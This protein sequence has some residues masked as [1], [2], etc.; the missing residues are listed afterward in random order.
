MEKLFCL[1]CKKE[2]DVNT[3]IWR[4][5]CGSILDI[6]VE[7]K[8]VIRRIKQRE[9]NLWRYL[10][11]LP[12]YSRSKVLSFGEGFTP[13]IDIPSGRYGEYRIL[14]KLEFLSPTGSFK[15]RGAT[16]LLSKANELGIKKVLCDSSGNAAAAV[17]AYASLGGID[18]DIYVPEYTEAG[19]LVQISMYGA[20]VIKVPGSRQDTSDAAFKAAQ[21]IY[22]ASHFWNPFFFQGTKTFSFEIWEQLNYHAPDN[23]IIP[24]GHGTLLLGAFKGFEELRKT[25]MIEKL[26]RI[27]AVQSESCAPIYEIFHNN[28][29]DIPDIKVQDNLAEGIS[30][31][32]PIRW[33]QIIDAIKS[34]SG[35]VLKVSDEEIKES[36]RE[37]SSKGLY[38]EPTSASATAALAKCIKENI[39]QPEE[40]TIV[41]LTGFGLKATDK[42][43]HMYHYI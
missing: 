26:P 30:I 39:I 14:F 13:L 43:G 10:E 36:L 4:C 27:I 32:R 7:S 8:F 3:P 38:F 16:V 29:K 9:K 40:F 17:A 33:M 2:F 35:T 28:L 25:Q 5:T 37:W 41:P 6:E 22:F 19:K 11:A 15:D 21:E 24:T 31:S 23:I 12:V 20:N 42:I 1:K 34:T 18:C